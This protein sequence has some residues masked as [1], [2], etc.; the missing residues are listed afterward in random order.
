MNKQTNKFTIK[1]DPIIESEI[2]LPQPSCWECFISIFNMDQ[3]KKI[4]YNPNMAHLGSRCQLWTIGSSN[5]I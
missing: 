2:S 1:L 5:N 3:L 4:L